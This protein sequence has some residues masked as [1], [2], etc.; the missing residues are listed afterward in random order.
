M[1]VNQKAGGIETTQQDRRQQAELDTPQRELTA[2]FSQTGRAPGT[3]GRASTITSCGGAKCVLMTRFPGDPE[4]PGSTI[5]H[6]LPRSSTS[7][8]RP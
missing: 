1:I 5:A 7:A 3:L 4:S 8:R 6:S 2:Q